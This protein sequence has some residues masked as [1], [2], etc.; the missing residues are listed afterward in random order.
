MP[1]N[2]LAEFDVKQR[3]KTKWR[4]NK[5]SEVNLALDKL[6]SNGVNFSPHLVC[7]P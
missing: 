4:W 3:L 6:T 5:N 2:P 7:L 1:V